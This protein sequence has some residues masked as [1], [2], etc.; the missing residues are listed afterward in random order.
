[1]SNDD[2]LMIEAPQANVDDALP[3]AQSAIRTTF[4]TGGAPLPD[5][6][7]A[8]G[9]QIFGLAL[10]IAGTPDILRKNRIQMPKN[11]LEKF[12]VLLIEDNPGDV[13]LL[14]EML[15][16]ERKRR[17]YIIEV[18]ATLSE[19]LRH[20]QSGGFD[21]ALL[22]LS[23]P[24]CSGLDSFDRVRAA[25]PELPIVILSDH[26]DG[27]RAL[28]A[29]QHGAQECLVKGRIDGTALNRAMR[30]AI[31]RAR[32]DAALARE[33]ELLNTLLENIPDRIYFK[34][35]RSRFIRINHALTEL[36]GLEKP[37]QAYGKT[38]ADF[39]GGQ[40]AGKA[41]ADERRVME[42]GE[43]LLGDIEF[44][45]LA[46]GRK[47]WSLTTKLPL[48]DRTGT[49][50]GTCGISREITEMKEMEERLATERNL[51]RSV[52]DNL[53]DRIYLK[54]AEGVYRLDNVA[55]QRW[56]GADDASEVLGRSVFDFFPDEIANHLH[57]IDCGIMESGEPQ[58]NLEEL[59]VDAEGQ[60]SWVL[61]T[62]V[63]WIDDVGSVLGIVCISRDIT[64]QKQNEESLRR[65][66][67]E[68][69]RSR[70][71]VLA[72]MQK[73]QA[74]HHELRD[75]QLQLIEAEKMKLVGRLA[76]GVAHEVKN[77]LAVVKM[78]TEFLSMHE[79][80][81][82]ADVRETLSGMADAVSRADA[83]IRGLLDF[84]AP[85]TLE[86]R[87]ES[88]NAVIERAITL[89][90]GDLKG[91]AVERELERSL[92]VVHLDVG[93]ISQV[94]IN[95]LTN[96]AHAMES[97]GTIIVRTYAKQLTGVGA[98]MSDQRVE[99]FRV[100]QTLIVA[101]IDDTGHGIP[102]EKLPKIFEPFFTTKPT[103]KGTG[104]GLSVVKTII[105]LHGATIDLRNLPSGGTRAT[106]MFRT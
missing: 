100:G 34:D 15:D 35:E 21:L 87:P 33:R 90:R 55:H 37:E 27:E 101:E 38:D 50:V 94:F 64:Q 48:R 75:V 29:V 6:P 32:S 99:S 66:N 45:I 25:A 81:G 36:F 40:H 56:L 52:I 104:L 59:L 17:F 85:K 60:P 12:R 39:Y 92:P 18:A 13:F 23:L 14:R 76:A 97:G 106:I 53:P 86:V 46:D 57:A 77:P 73:L 62:K 63:P 4:P 69:N 3:H 105:D 11:V 43:P 51:L 41:L 1:M 91:I 72:A 95:I 19:G 31:E 93:K 78:G 44:E 88:L 24:D 61:T 16:A 79:M 103:G 42:T 22:D 70:E 49:I 84:S 96:A 102:E 47:S 67:V 10:A 9:G 74:A 26:D 71:E 28:E 80:A 98:N 68:L 58:L 83:V 2:H 30:Y 89:V 65:A 7:N 5:G 54:D 20:I 8:S 82:D